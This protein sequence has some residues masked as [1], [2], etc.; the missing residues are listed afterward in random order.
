MSKNSIDFAAISASA[1]YLNQ[2][3]DSFHNLLTNIE[4]TIVNLGIGLELWLTGVE[5]F[6]PNP[7]QDY[8]GSKRGWTIGL[9]KHDR[10]WCVAV[11]EA[12]L[13]D[14]EREMFLC[15]PEDNTTPLLDAPRERRIASLK[16]I[17]ALVAR[18]N[19]EA[20]RAAKVMDEAIA[21][22]RSIDRSLSDVD[23]IL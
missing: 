5:N 11:R 23:D 20:Q 7:T 22:A 6:V 12:F 17:P 4:S 2:Q 13:N 16:L 1:K 14:N 3:S 18:L 19:E 10:S 9:T 8:Y 21:Q 15:N